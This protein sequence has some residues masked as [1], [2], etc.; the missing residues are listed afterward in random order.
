MDEITATV[1][2]GL[3]YISLVLICIALSLLYGIL[4]NWLWCQRKDWF[5]TFMIVIPLFLLLSFISYILGRGI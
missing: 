5:L 4:L 1:I 3:P 2:A